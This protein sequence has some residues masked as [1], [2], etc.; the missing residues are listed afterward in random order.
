MG[1][2][3]P[4]RSR[5]RSAVATLVGGLWGP[6]SGA[7][8]FV[9]LGSFRW[10]MLGTLVPESSRT[11]LGTISCCPLAPWP[12]SRPISTGAFETCFPRTL[13]ASGVSDITWKV[14]CARNELQRAQR[15]LSFLPRG[16]G[17]S[18]TTPGTSRWDWLS[19][20]VSWERELRTPWVTMATQLQSCE[21]AS[22]PCRCAQR[23]VWGSLPLTHQ[24]PPGCASCPG[25]GRGQG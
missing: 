20:H 14:S 1:P 11:S 15:R 10:T 17:H 13:P 9:F 8:C 25:P 3:Q 16:P 2:A 19:P 5:S 24:S 21:P 23:R 7:G 22:T 18:P 4:G 6:W 12:S